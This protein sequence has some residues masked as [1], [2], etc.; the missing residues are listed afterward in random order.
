MSQSNEKHEQQ[1]KHLDEIAVELEKAVAHAK[2]A[3]S[4]FR[5]GEVPRGCAHAVA[6]EGH[7]IAANEHAQQIAKTHRLAAKP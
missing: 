1:A 5:S 2:T 6:V 3:A 4:H 7:L